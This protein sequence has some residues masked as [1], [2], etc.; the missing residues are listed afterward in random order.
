[1]CEFAV[2]GCGPENISGQST[3]NIFDMPA[4]NVKTQ[5]QKQLQIGKKVTDPLAV[6]AR[7]VIKQEITTTQAMQRALAETTAW[8][9]DTTALRN[10]IRTHE[11]QFHA[12][13]MAHMLDNS[14]V[15]PLPSLHSPSGIAEAL[16][17]VFFGNYQYGSVTPGTGQFNAE[18]TSALPNTAMQ[19][20]NPSARYSIFHGT[21]QS[22]FV[23]NTDTNG[24]SELWITF[25][26]N[27]PNFPVK[28]LDMTAPT[29]PLA[30]TST[31]TIPWTDNPFVLTQSWITGPTLDEKLQNNNNT[32]GPPPPQ[33]KPLGEQGYYRIHDPEVGT[34][35]TPAI[36]QDTDT[37][38]LY[39][40]GGASMELSHT[41]IDAY[42]TTA[43]RVR[44][45][46]NY[47]H[48]FFDRLDNIYNNTA[49]GFREPYATAAAATS[50]HSGSQWVTSS[51]ATAGVAPGTVANQALF[52]VKGFDNCWQQGCPMIQVK[53]STVNPNIAVK[54]S[55]TCKVWKAVA[56][57]GLGV[58]GAMPRETVPFDLP[59]WFS[60]CRM[61]GGV[62]K[63]MNAAKSAMNDR[64]SYAVPYMT[65]GSPL[66]RAVA[67]SK[68]P[69]S[70]IAPLL[71]HPAVAAH[72]SWATEA[73]EGVGGL[74]V[75][76]EFTK[77]AG[78][79]FTRILAGLRTAAP[80][81]EEVAPLLM[82]A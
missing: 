20:A 49:L 25:D 37:T 3:H 58:A 50:F 69:A 8:R 35:P 53:S 26:P 7:K 79:L 57:Y 78:P 24:N 2:G 73:L 46:S 41:N 16:S 61:S 67:V 81:A 43:F 47:T 10:Y 64:V 9:Q 28:I 62:G 63:T 56:P 27:D 18:F 75:A 40:N 51:R 72:N 52:V 39:W 36:I 38:N 34:Y 70:A 11:D 82:L 17:A 22:E 29:V 48:R 45:M 55:V 77:R 21:V 65:S 13:L 44:K 4:K 76:R 59:S 14:I 30:H 60:L 33:S 80:V 54:F 42:T 1:M 6:E 68:A 74:S 66:Q 12:S 31:F 23:V 71:K 19:C 5:Q 15:Y 32:R